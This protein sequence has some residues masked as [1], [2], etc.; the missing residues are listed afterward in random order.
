M[1]HRITNCRGTYINDVRFLGGLG[2]SSKIGQN[3]TNSDN[4][5]ENENR[6]SHYSGFLPFFSQIFL[7]KFTPMLNVYLLL[8]TLVYQIDVQDEISENSRKTLNVQDRINMQGGKIS[9]NQ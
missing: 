8:S 6:T 1:Y 7:L 2:G 5:N 9:Q 4:E 3:R